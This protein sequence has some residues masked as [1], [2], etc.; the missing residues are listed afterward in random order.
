MTPHRTAVEHDGRP[1]T[2]TYAELADRVGRLAR[3]LTR[4][5]LGRGDRVAYLGPND[6]AFLIGLFATGN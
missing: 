4:L 3:R 1:P 2:T 5:G 6:P